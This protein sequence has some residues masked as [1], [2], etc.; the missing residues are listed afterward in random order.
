[1]PSTAT[2]LL[3]DNFKS[4]D[5]SVTTSAASYGNR[6]TG[7]FLIDS[8]SEIKQMPNKNGTYNFTYSKEEIA[9]ATKI[10]FNS[11]KGNNS[12]LVGSAT[13]NFL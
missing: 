10:V 9:G 3:P 13:I 5:I 12:I 11:G 1:M 6:N 2:V 7:F 4:I 8:L